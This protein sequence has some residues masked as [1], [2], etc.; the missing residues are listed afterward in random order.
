MSNYAAKA[1]G[2]GS[3][4]LS[5]LL[6]TAFPA[7]V[8]S[9]DEASHKAAVQPLYKQDDGN[10][11]PQIQGVPVAK[12][13]YKIL[14]NKISTEQANSHSHSYSWTSEGGSGTTGSTPAHT[15]DI[16]FTEVVEEIKLFLK[17]GDLVLCVCSEKS[18]DAMLTK[19][20]HNPQSK[21]TFDL[22]DAIIVCIL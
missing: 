20:I 8:V 14:K 12:W 5:K 22:S 1:M 4:N 15:H 19:V 16:Q 18:I 11:Y 3:D 2:A 17:Q 13:R 7:I 10:N 21:R 9:Y 6:H